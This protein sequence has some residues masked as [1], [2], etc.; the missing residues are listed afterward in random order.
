MIDCPKGCT[1]SPLGLFRKASPTAVLRKM[2]LVM[3]DDS[4]T[5]TD[6]AL[7]DDATADDAT[8]DDSLAAYAT[9]DDATTDDATSDSD[10]A[11]DFSDYMY[12]NDLYDPGLSP[13]A[14]ADDADYSGG[15]LPMPDGSTGVGPGIYE[16]WQE[17]EEEQEEEREE[18]QEQWEED[19]EQREE[20]EQQRE[21]E[22]E[23]REEEE[24][25]REERN[26]EMFGG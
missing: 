10:G 11:P 12:Q 14:V 6:D 22:V 16:V 3:S 7:T 23:Q 18:Q 26:Y 20:Q 19:E 4:I 9:A 21:Q 5:D 13:S 8:T 1:H 24:E 17:E 2:L 15:G 25:E